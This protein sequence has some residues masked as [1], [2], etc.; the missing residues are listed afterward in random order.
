VRVALQGV[1][2]S[3]RGVEWLTEMQE[4]SNL[5]SWGGTHVHD[6]AT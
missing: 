1:G 6:L 4:S 5:R 3:E 2:Q